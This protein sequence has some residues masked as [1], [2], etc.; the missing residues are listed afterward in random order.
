MVAIFLLIAAAVLAVPLVSG[1]AGS[2]RPR[3]R[4]RDHRLRYI[5][6][7]PEQVNTG[8]ICRLLAREL[9]RA[10]V[11]LIVERAETLGVRPWTMLS[12]IQR[13]DVH[14]LAVVIAAELSHEELL[15]HLGNGT[16]PDL[17]ELELFAAINGLPTGP[18]RAG[19]AAPRA[20]LAS[21]ARAAVRTPAPSVPAEPAAATSKMPPIFEP[22]SW[23]YDQFGLDLPAWPDEPSSGSSG[24]LA[25]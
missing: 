11:D 23:P 2:S 5:A 1:L 16:L 25:A 20:A 19:R 24:P 17:G 3:G 18:T 21:P 4:E 14:T 13:Y 12:W 10:D 15:L 22:G 7:H 6:R 9:D 8:D